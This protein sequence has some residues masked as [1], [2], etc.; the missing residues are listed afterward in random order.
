MLWKYDLGSIDGLIA[1][2]PS[3]LKWKT[4]IKVNPTCQLCDSDEEI[5]EHFILHC[6][7]LENTRNSDI[8]DISHE[9]NSVLDNLVLKEDI[10]NWLGQLAPQFM[11]RSG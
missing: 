2:P 9:V 10:F 11:V 8:G 6:S 1:D 7:A 3:K 4:N 5:L